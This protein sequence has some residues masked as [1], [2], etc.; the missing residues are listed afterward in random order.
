MTETEPTKIRVIYERPPNFDKIVQFFPLATRITTVF[1]YGDRIYVPEGKPLPREI[2]A[3]V[4]D[5]EL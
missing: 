4:P 1:S 5:G 3:P 2:V